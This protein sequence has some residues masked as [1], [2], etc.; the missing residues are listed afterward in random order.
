[1]ALSAIVRCGRRG[2]RSWPTGQGSSKVVHHFKVETA[3]LADFSNTAALDCRPFFRKSHG[4][5]M[6]ALTYITQLTILGAFCVL[7]TEEAQAQRTSLSHDLDP[8]RGPPWGQG[9]PWADQEPYAPHPKPLDWIDSNP[10]RWPWT[11]NRDPYGDAGS[12]EWKEAPWV[13]PGVQIA[14]RQGRLNAAVPFIA[15]MKFPA[16]AEVPAHA[17]SAVRHVR[18]LSGVLNLGLGDRLGANQT[19]NDNMLALFC[20]FLKP[21]RAQWSQRF[22]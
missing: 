13:G 19:T 21:A 17:H 5:V 6:K 1:M 7:A 12:G 10:S 15:R 22:G 11:G 20:E 3:A 4:R 14:V 2:T 9:G 8:L 18:V 16:N